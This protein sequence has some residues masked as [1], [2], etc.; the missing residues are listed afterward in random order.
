MFRPL[1]SSDVGEFAHAISDT[2]KPMRTTLGLIL[3]VIGLG[4][5]LYGGGTAVRE[6]V[7]FYR[8]TVDNPMDDVEGGS[9][10]VSDRMLG[11]AMIGGVGAVPFVIGSMILKGE[12]F[13]RIRRAVRGK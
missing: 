9:Q 10:G 7:G 1:T 11:G 8:S 6:L 13:R 4:V 3:V 5:I 2:L 12:A